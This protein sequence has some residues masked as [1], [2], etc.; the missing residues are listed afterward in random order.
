MRSP[1]TATAPSSITWR[2]A[3]M[4]MTYRA[5]Q[6]T[7][8]GSAAPS[9][10]TKRKK[11]KIRDIEGLR[12]EFF[13]VI[14]FGLALQVHQ[15]EFHVSAELPQNLPARAAWRRQLGRIGGH[16]HPAEFSHAFRDRL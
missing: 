4:V 15:H 8:A 5:L 2:C 6:M 7:S 9:V 1:L 11:L 13:K 12:E 14:G 10:K 3:S 16:G